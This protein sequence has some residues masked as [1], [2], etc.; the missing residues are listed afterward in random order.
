MQAPGWIRLLRRIPPHQIENLSLVTING[1]ELSVQS[2]VR[3]EEEFVLIRARV[4]GSS[5][6]GRAFFV[7]YD[8]INFLGFQKPIKE[9][10]LRK[11]FTGPQA[12]PTAEEQAAA[13]QYEA[14]VEPLEAEEPLALPEEEAVTDPS[15]PPSTPAP[16][17]PQEARV[18]PSKSK[19]LANL[20]AR[21]KSGGGSAP[22]R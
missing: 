5:D 22:V 6:A 17:G 10:E 9:D 7:P 18:L 14:E 12:W 2:L 4:S 15:P 8:Q 13:E 19:V 11:I 1:I 3:I 16:A 21:L 20:R